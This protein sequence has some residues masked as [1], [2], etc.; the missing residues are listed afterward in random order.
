MVVQLTLPINLKIIQDSDLEVFIRTDA[1]GAESAAKVLGTDY[2]M[3][4]AG[5]ST[6]GSVT[7]LSGKIPIFR[8][9]CCI[10]KECSQN[11]SN[12]LYC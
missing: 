12:R 1:T 11:P 6:G 9:N 3:T 10:E 7:F 5:V 4:G 2:S 8:T